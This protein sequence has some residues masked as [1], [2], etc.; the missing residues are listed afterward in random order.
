MHATIFIDS[1]KTYL[2]RS[3]LKPAF[4]IGIYHLLPE[5]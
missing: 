2:R 3:M 5:K 1:L 4:Y